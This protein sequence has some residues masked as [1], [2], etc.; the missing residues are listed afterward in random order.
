MNGSTK[1]GSKGGFVPDTFGRDFAASVVVF[2]VAMPLCLGIAIAS[3]VPPALGLVTGIIGGIA[4]LL[5]GLLI[6][7][8]LI[9]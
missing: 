4:W 7:S 8:W 5:L 1:S 9:R 3:G 2:L 6:L